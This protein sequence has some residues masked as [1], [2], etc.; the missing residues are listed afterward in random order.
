MILA[1]EQK[2]DMIC[3]LNTIMMAFMTPSMPRV[4][5]LMPEDRQILWKRFRV[6]S[7][8]NVPTSSSLE[9]R[10]LISDFLVSFLMTSLSILLCLRVVIFC[11][12]SRCDRMY[13]ISPPKL[14]TRAAL[15]S[16][17]IIVLLSSSSSSSLFYGLYCN[18]VC[19][20][21]L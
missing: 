19:V 18:S 5:N 11:D 12:R 17:D 16:L 9:N 3:H 4:L 14:I 20:C 1:T 7:K 15:H 6:I 13:T 2:D 21:V 8:S 10:R